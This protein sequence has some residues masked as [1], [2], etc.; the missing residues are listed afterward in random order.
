M[1]SENKKAAVV[2]CPFAHSGQDSHRMKA[3]AFYFMG[4]K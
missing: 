3:A 4:K 2:V 1:F